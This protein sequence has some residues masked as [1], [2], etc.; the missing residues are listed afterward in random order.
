MSLSLRP[1]IFTPDDVPLV[2]DVELARKNPALAVLS[3]ICHG[4]DA[5]VDAMF[6]ALA[7][8]LQSV[9]PGT[10]ISY[11]DVV[12]AGLPQAAQTRWEAFMTTTA[13]QEFISERL[14]KLVAEN[15]AIGE[16]RGEARGHL[17]GEA[18]AVLL[19]LEARGVTVP[20]E[21]RERIL[22]CTDRELLDLWAHRAATATTITD[23]L[24]P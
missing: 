17:R 18:R 16:T 20:A 8:A 24:A 2:M 10:A 13:D 19:V 15:Q 5:A 4:G 3:A 12:L 11:Y 9:G 6:P 1:F 14:R 23:L 22:T 21:S 7:A